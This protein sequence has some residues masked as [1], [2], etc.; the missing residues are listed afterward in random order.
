MVTRPLARPS[1]PEW[2]TLFFQRDRPLR[3]EFVVRAVPS[4]SAPMSLM[5]LLLEREE[6]ERERY[7]DD[8]DSAVNI[9]F[10]SV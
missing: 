5:E 9:F 4:S 8:C 7:Y 6:R 10:V 2:N 3:V 1:A